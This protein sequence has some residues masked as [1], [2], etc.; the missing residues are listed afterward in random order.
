MRSEVC[1]AVSR[2]QI[3]INFLDLF[4]TDI[5][6][7]TNSRTVLFQDYAE[8]QTVSCISMAMISFCV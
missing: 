5:I 7:Y 8:V 1:S 2:L 4:A 6:T 3:T